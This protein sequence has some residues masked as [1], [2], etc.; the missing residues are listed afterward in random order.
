MDFNSFLAKLNIALG[1]SDNFTYT[2]EEK[3]RALTEAFNDP[4]AVTNTWNT[5]LSFTTGTY[6]YALPTGTTTVRDIYIKADNSQ[7]YPEKIDSGLWEVVGSNI[8]FMPGSDVIPQGY[9]LY[10]RGA[11]KIGVADT[12]TDVALQEYILTV[13]QFRCLKLLG[14]K[15]INRFLKN[16]T[17]VAELI[18]LKRD[19]EQDMMAYRRRLPTQYQVG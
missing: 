19:L 13:A 18:T 11:N 9:A 8:Q 2:P 5:T 17:T 3:T 12:V 14:N 10:V 15:K 7:D 1:D 16:D 4:Y 6:Q